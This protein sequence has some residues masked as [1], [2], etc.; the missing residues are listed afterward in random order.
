VTPTPAPRF[1]EASSDPRLV[2][3]M[4]KAYA[5]AC[6]MLHDRGQP[7][8][9]QEIIAGRIV[10]IVKTGERDPNRVCQRVLIDVGL[11]PDS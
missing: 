10:E 3:V 6:R 5:K 11:Q 4:T 9:V 8:L 7:A 2:D 1:I